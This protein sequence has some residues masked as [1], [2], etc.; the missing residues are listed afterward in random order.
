MLYDVQKLAHA[1]HTSK[2]AEVFGAFAD[3]AAGKKDAG[4]VLLFNDDVGIS[5]IVLEV[6]VEARLIMLDKGVL[7]QEGIV[8]RV[9]DGEFYV[10]YEGDEA[11]RLVVVVALSEVRGHALAQ[12]FGLAYVQE[13]LGAVVILIASRLMRN[14]GCYLAESFFGHTVG[15]NLRLVLAHKAVIYP[16]ATC[17]PDQIVLRFLNLDDSERHIEQLPS[18]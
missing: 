1:P 8:L 4:E 5:L 14:R 2:R 18:S 13:L 3:N 12:V 9:R 17:I 15:L 7:Q 11:A 10:I 6:N 16:E